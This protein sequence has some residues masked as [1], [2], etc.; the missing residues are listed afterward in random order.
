MASKTSPPRRSSPLTNSENFAALQQQVIG[1][2]TDYQELKGVVVSL[3]RKM[4]HGFTAIHTKLDERNRTQ[5]PVIFSGLAVLL[6]FCVSVGTLAYWPIK[7]DIA[8]IKDDVV[9]MSDRN[10]LLQREFDFL[11]GQLHQQLK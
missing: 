5:W 2:D 7:S 10:H 3:D 4:D 6:T 11:R 1:L 8:A 9:R